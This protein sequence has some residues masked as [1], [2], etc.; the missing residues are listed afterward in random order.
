[1]LMGGLSPI[2]SF[3]SQSTHSSTVLEGSILALT[4]AHSSMS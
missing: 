2:S 4:L 3:F 1:M